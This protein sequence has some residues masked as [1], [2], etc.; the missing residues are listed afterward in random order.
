MAA[1]KAEA[2]AKAVA[3]REEIVAEGGGHRREA[4]ED[5]PLEGRH[6]GASRAARRL[7]GGAE[8]GRPHRQGGREGAVDSASPTPARA[9]SSARKHHFAE[10]DKV[11]AEVAARKEALVGTRRGARG[12]Q[13]LG[14]DRAGVPRPH[15]RMEG[16]GTGTT[17]VGRRAVGASSVRRRTP[18]STRSASRPRRPSR[19]SRANLPAKEAAVADAEGAPADPRPPGGQGGPPRRPGPLRGRGRGS[20]GRRR[21]PEQAPGRRRARGTR[22]RGRR[23]GEVQPR[24]RG[25]RERCRRAADRGD[26]GPRR[27]RSPRRRNPATRRRSPSSTESRDARQAWL[28]QIKASVS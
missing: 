18:S 4:D 11:N 6:R 2:R 24:A 3:E 8:G 16:G 17:L 26:R 25:P 21:A 10:L 9:S 12:V 20:P 13:G 27:V 22:G 28:D 19:R 5:R 23:V 7:E 14:L 1:A 15:G